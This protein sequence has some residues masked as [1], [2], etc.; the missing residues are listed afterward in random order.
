MEEND[1]GIISSIVSVL[2]WGL[3]ESVLLKDSVRLYHYV[4]SM[5]DEW[6]INMEK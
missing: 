1:C 4:G 6:N 3:E 5:V 2:A